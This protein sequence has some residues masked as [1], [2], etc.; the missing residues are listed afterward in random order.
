LTWV[1]ENNVAVQI[2]MVVGGQPI[3]LPLGADTITISM[4]EAVHLILPVV[5]ITFLDMAGLDDKFALFN[6]GQAFTLAVSPYNPNSKL[7]GLNFRIYSTPTHRVTSSGKVIDILAYMDSPFWVK[8]LRDYLFN[9]F[10][11]CQSSKIGV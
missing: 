5:R 11:I 6:D 7:N 8:F 9:Y 1:L 10:A 4:V 2:G 3:A